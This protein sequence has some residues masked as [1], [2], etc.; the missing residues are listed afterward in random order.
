MKK[1]LLALSILGAFAGVAHA[2]TNVTM[3]GIID[4]GISRDDTGNQK[5]TTLRSGNQSQSRLGFRGTEDL[6]SGLKAIFSLETG[7][8]IAKGGFTQGNTAFAR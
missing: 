4:A 7:I 6:G 1:S 2:Q 5:V 8:D 3:Y